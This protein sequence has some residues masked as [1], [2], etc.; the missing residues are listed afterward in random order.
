[1][2]WVVYLPV[3][4]GVATFSISNLSQLLKRQKSRGARTTHAAYNFVQIVRM[5]VHR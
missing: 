3:P 1:M 2:L 4:F 5:T